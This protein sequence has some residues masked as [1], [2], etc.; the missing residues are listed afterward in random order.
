[1]DDV[2]SPFPMTSADTYES[3]ESRRA[4]ARRIGRIILAHED[5]LRLGRLIVEPPMRR[6]THEDGR[7]EILE[8]RVMQ[9]LVALLRS[10]GA[11]LTRHDLTHCCWDG[12][13]VGDDAINRVMS[14]LRRTSEGLGNGIFRIETINKVGYRLLDESR[15]NGSRVER[16]VRRTADTPMGAPRESVYVMV[17]SEPGATCMDLLGA[18]K[19][20][21]LVGLI[22]AITGSVD[23]LV[24]LDGDNIAEISKSRSKIA[25]IPGVLSATSAVV[26]ERYVG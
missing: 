19:Q 21:P 20:V 6:I 8:P 15:L 11:I 3:G 16:D 5:P 13:I 24:R 22:H 25:E 14:R 2:V 12:R 1:M 18:L 10:G 23:L 26:L 9:V 17:T 4:T 7:E